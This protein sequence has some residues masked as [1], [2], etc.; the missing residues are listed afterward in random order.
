MTTTAQIVAKAREFLGT[1]LHHQGRIKGKR[2]DC[3]GLALCVAEELGLHDKNGN[4]LHGRDQ[5]NYGPQPLGNLVHETAKARLALKWE[6]A[7]KV[8][9]PAIAPGDVL[10]IRNPNAACHAG[11]VSSLNGSLAII[12][13]YASGPARPGPRNKQRVCEHVLDASWRA[14]IE[15]I[16]EFPGVT[17]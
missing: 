13:A 6:A 1:P 12:H 3:V 7:Q 9:M 5:L 2:I 14:R 10:T 15:G 4:A 17:S 16:F 11:I 8:P